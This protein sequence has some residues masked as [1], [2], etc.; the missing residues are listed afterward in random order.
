[1]IDTLVPARTKNQETVVRLGTMADLDR[2][3]LTEG[4]AASITEK[5]WAATTIADI[6][7]HARVSKRTFYEHFGDKRD[8]FL[9]VYSSVSDAL[10]A[11]IE[12]SADPA[13]PWREQVNAAARAYVAALESQP[14]LTRAFFLEIQSAG[15]EAL[16]LRLEV[17]QR[18]AELLRK[19]VA[20][21]RKNSTE[22]V[23]PL[24]PAMAIA[25]VGGINELLLVSICSEEAAGLSK[26]AKVAAE[27]VRTVV[28][29]NPT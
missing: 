23:R 21:A 5:G 18:F 19:L 13:L 22:I 15:P 6:V 29:T 2:A 24:S 20:R 1:M 9:A 3:R 25:I 16:A 26:V 17:N 28:E 7:R 14:A 12:A 10:L 11:T 4:L 27:L 8:C